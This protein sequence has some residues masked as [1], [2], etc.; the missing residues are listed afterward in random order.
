MKK[1]TKLE[2]Y[3]MNLLLYQVL[4]YQVETQEFL[5]WEFGKTVE[6]EKLTLEA[7]CLTLD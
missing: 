4:L 1:G 7:T 6:Q 3:P 5:P 2:F